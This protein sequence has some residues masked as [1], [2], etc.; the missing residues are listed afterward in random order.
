MYLFKVYI[1]SNY[2]YIHIYIGVLFLI[3][4]IL[5]SH[6]RVT[7]LWYADGARVG[8]KLPHILAHLRDLQARGP[9]RGYFLNPTKS[10]LF[11]ALCNVAWTEELFIGVGIKVVTGSRYLWGFIGEGEAEKSCLVGKVVGWSKFVETIAGVSRKNPRSAYAGLQ[12]PIHQKWAFLQWVNLGIGNAFSLVEK[13]LQ[14]TF[15]PDLFEG[16]WE[17]A[18]GAT[19]HLPASETGSTG[20]SR[21]NTDVP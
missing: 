20:P 1:V 6:T 4:E 3:M 8:R 19:G 5:G 7:N 9:P 14:E 10:I 13:S 17:G 18:P 2:I 11:V 12:K 15:L 16:L 21:P